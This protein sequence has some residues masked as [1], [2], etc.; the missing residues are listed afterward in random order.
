MM[1]KTHL[2]FS[3]IVL[4]IFFQEVLHAQDPITLDWSV[5]ARADLSCDG[6]GVI[7]IDIHGAIDPVDVFW[8]GPNG[9]YHETLDCYWSY[10]NCNRRISD[11][12]SGL[13]SVTVEDDACR[14]A[15]MDVEIGC[16]DCEHLIE[17]INTHGHI[18][19][20]PQKG[21][22]SVGYTNAGR[23]KRPTW[24]NGQRTQTIDN[25]DAGYYSVTVTDVRGCSDSHG[26]YLRVNNPP[27][28]TEDSDFTIEE[29]CSE[30]KDGEGS[31]Q[32]TN[33]AYD[34]YEYEWTGP[35]GFKTMEQ[36]IYFLVAGTYQVSMTDPV[37]GCI[38]RIGG[39]EV[40]SKDILTGYDI[41]HA[42]EI[43]NCED[44]GIDLHLDYS[45]GPFR[46]E[47]T[48]PT[49][50]VWRIGNVEEPDDYGED[51]PENRDPGIYSV[52]IISQKC[53]VEKEFEIE[54]LPC[55]C[56]CT[57][58][59]EVKSRQCNGGRIIQENSSCETCNGTF[60]YLWSDG[61]TDKNRTNLSSGTY[62]VTI[63]SSDGCIY[64]RSFEIDDD[65]Y[66]F[67]VR[68]NAL[69]NP[70]CQIHSPWGNCDGYI[71]V[72]AWGGIR[73][74]ESVMTMNGTVIDYR[75]DCGWNPVWADLCPG[76]YRIEFTDANGCYRFLDF[77]ITCCQSSGDIQIDGEVFHITDAN[78]N[79][80]ITTNVS[81]GNGDYYC[82]WRDE[83]GSPWDVL[84]NN[85]DGLYFLE[86]G[87]YCL[88]VMDGCQY[89]YG[90]ETQCF[91]LV[92]CVERRNALDLSAILAA[93][94]CQDRFF[95][96]MWNGEICIQGIPA[97][98]GDI[99]VNYT[100]NWR[101]G[102][103]PASRDFTD[104]LT[105]VDGDCR[106]ITGV[107]AGDVEINIFD[108]DGCKLGLLNIEVLPETGE[109]ISEQS[110]DGCDEVLKCFNRV[111]EP[112]DDYVEVARIDGDRGYVAGFLE[113]Y[114]DLCPQ[115]EDSNLGGD[116]VCI[117]ACVVGNNVDFVN[118]RP[119]ICPN[120][121]VEESHP[122]CGSGFCALIWECS[123]GDP[124]IQCEPL[125]ANEGGEV[126]TNFNEVTQKCEIISASPLTCFEGQTYVEFDPEYGE[127]QGW[128][129]GDG[130]GAYCIRYA[131]CGQN[132]YLVRDYAA[133]DT[134]YWYDC[135]GPLS[136]N[137]ILCGTN[138]VD[139]IPCAGLWPGGETDSRKREWLENYLAEKNKWVKIYP[140]PF[141]SRLFIDVL[142]NGN[143][144]VEIMNV[145]KTLVHKS[146]ILDDTTIPFQ[147]R[148]DGVYIISIVNL[149]TGNSQKEIVLHVSE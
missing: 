126:Q 96:D 49:G 107:R 70:L 56:D 71:N 113:E 44:G 93:R 7:Q 40:P 25:L 19:C 114:R 94:S 147:N 129:T 54:C 148:P 41:K 74:I 16:E 30:S 111:L 136:A 122:Y 120:V 104:V 137:Y 112:L 127:W 82:S 63:S 61:S 115:N 138:R 36:D 52:K 128:E 4:L 10:G 140:N 95:D 45:E 35:G 12:A 65:S 23:L 106:L 101:S 27:E 66:N 141:S 100:I 118:E 39:V 72:F 123:D 149:D 31:I 55:Q 121:R 51:I 24:S 69:E 108:S 142:K 50:Y 98:Y 90:S 29:D 116:I 92:D 6:G 2:I 134:E 17:Y 131:T 33:T 85:C 53:T 119:P 79:G 37:T 87:I 11:L 105:A 89:I 58:E 76:A 139:S 3:G 86:A 91:E 77:S 102:G 46:I 143:Y 15:Y 109:W 146:V 47:W 34:H 32:V 67:D 1:T 43:N 22:L 5:P 48:D 59:Y 83:A 110:G 60:D 14:H 130:D 26:L 80:Y 57:F 18:D 144:A 42:Y 28:P 75:A 73:P 99:Y 103:Y 117:D 62:T 97:D 81:G 13:Y 84:S 124:H 21:K 20:E 135:D 9:Y 88:D 68:I 133:W 38:E 125:Y 132:D 145:N 8:S 64:V 78:P